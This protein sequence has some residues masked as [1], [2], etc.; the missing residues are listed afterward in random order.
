MTTPTKKK[1]V[2]G[3]AIL[4]SIGAGLWALNHYLRDL[5]DIFTDERKLYD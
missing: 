4:A 3:I 1:L 5:E 2:L